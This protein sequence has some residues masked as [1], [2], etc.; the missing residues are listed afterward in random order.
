[1]QE[2][3]QL[4]EA[5][6]PALQAVPRHTVALLQRRKYLQ[7]EGHH[8][9]IHILSELPTHDSTL[10]QLFTF[11]Q[12][13]IKRPNRSGRRAFTAHHQF[14]RKVLAGK[15]SQFRREFACN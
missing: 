15:K 14:R 3:Q 10:L 4:S 12:K 7:V 11:A 1:V 2:V 9:N 13:P 8:Y 6:Q 5:L